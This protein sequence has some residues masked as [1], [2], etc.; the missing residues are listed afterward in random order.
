MI[1]SRGLRSPPRAAPARN[2]TMRAKAARI[3]TITDSAFSPIAPVADLWFEVVEA[4]FEGFRSLAVTMALAM[5]L[6]VALAQR[7]GG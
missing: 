3:V 1:S 6:S 4:N 2:P 5:S 7:R